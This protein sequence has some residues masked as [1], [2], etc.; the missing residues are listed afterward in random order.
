VVL[1]TLKKIGAAGY[2]TGVEG[3]ALAVLKCTRIADFAEL[4]PLLQK[5]VDA[6]DGVKLDHKFAPYQGT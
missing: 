1:G 4:L 2:G 5:V 3:G 6:A